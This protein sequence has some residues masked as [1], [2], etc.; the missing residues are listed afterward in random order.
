MVIVRYRYRVKNLLFSLLWLL[1][2][3][4]LLP[5][6]C[7]L[8]I[9]SEDDEWMFSQDSL[10]LANHLCAAYS[11]TLPTIYPTQHNM[12]G[13]NI[14]LHIFALIL[15]HSGTGISFTLYQHCY[16]FMIMTNTK[17]FGNGYLYLAWG[18]VQSLHS[19]L[20]P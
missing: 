20:P 10:Y 7:R 6:T 13:T 16:S 2:S 14:T 15:G 18:R 1:Y 5:H 19:P 17:Y 3:G 4:N 12:T 8:C 9:L 11:G